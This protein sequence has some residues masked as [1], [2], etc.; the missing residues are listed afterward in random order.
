MRLPIVVCIP[1]T[2][3]MVWRADLHVDCSAC[4]HSMICGLLSL[5]SDSLTPKYKDHTCYL[6]KKECNLNL[7]YDIR[8][9]YKVCT[10]TL[11]LQLRLAIKTATSGSVTVICQIKNNNRNYQRVR[12]GNCGE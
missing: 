1:I 9:N 4:I 7:F 11:R 8:S 3:T 6:S 10:Q 12:A 2:T 5:A